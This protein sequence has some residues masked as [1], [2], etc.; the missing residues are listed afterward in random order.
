MSP[1][2]PPHPQTAP[3]RA[4]TNFHEIWVCPW[5][6]LHLH[7]MSLSDAW[8]QSHPN[9]PPC[10]FSELIIQADPIVRVNKSCV[11]VSYI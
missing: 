10:S 6:K 8:T 3:F 9:R 2:H 7:C 5:K 1:R 11:S 4:F